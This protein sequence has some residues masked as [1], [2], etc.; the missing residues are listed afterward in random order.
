M[1]GDSTTQKT[2]LG[3]RPK[4]YGKALKQRKPEVIRMR[5]VNKMVTA[6]LILQSSFIFA[7]VETYEPTSIKDHDRVLCISDENVLK[8]DSEDDR[9]MVPFGTLLKVSEIRGERCLVY[10]H[11]VDGWIETK[12]L[13]SLSDT[14]LPKIIEDSDASPAYKEYALGNYYS[15]R[16]LRKAKQY[17]INAIALDSNFDHAYVELVQ[18]LAILG[19]DK[20]IDAILAELK[21]F[22]HR[23]DVFQAFTIQKNASKENLLQCIE[24]AKKSSFLKT[25]LANFLLL[26]EDDRLLA[27]ASDF[28]LESFADQKMNPWRSHVLAM[29]Y[30]AMLPALQ[31]D[32]ELSQKAIQMA[33]AMWVESLKRD[34]HYA[35]A[36][37]CLALIQVRLGK[38]GEAIRLAQAALRVNPRSHVAA[39]II[40]KFSEQVEAGSVFKDAVGKE[41]TPL[42]I[43]PMSEIERGLKQI[44]GLELAVL[45]SDIREQESRL[46][47]HTDILTGRK[48]NDEGETALHVLV[49]DGNGVCLSYLASAFRV[50]WNVENA[51]GLTPLQ[52]A[53]KNNDLMVVSMLVRCGVDIN[54]KGK[55]HV[56]P[57]EMACTMGSPTMVAVLLRSNQVSPTEFA[58]PQ[59]YFDLKHE[60][61]LNTLRQAANEKVTDALKRI[62]KTELIA[63]TNQLVN[64]ESQLQSDRERLQLKNDWIPL[65]NVPVVVPGYIQDVGK[66]NP[67]RANM[68][69]NRQLAQE[70]QEHFELY[71]REKEYL[72][73]QVQQSEEN[74][75]QLREKATAVAD[76]VMAIAYY[77]FSSEDYSSF[78]KD[79][80]AQIKSILSSASIPWRL[81]YTTESQAKVT[82]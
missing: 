56:S 67:H 26:K 27:S 72:E 17:F 48:V 50:N 6:F 22:P 61:T 65:S 74:T 59:K 55:G 51:A 76:E 63:L 57:L 11:F 32:E 68:M 18:L 13:V 10:N 69:L 42:E 19:E 39:L 40:A 47:G 71:S 36:Y 52:L 14:D 58:T 82:E 53:I 33:T 12:R 70:S 81:P 77:T 16:D 43:L 49:K 21:R 3:F 1:Q 23:E 46:H 37:E 60:S 66:Y 25:E 79:T 62:V 8:S 7:Q 64:A 20:E 28:A 24:L 34:H 45:P 54:H 75:V 73:E 29:V 5:L 80:G 30:F 35:V 4:K 31:E 78:A 38:N 15:R 41:I 44:A 2:T 9:H